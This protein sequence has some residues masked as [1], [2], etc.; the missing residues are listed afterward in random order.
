MLPIGRPSRSVSRQAVPPSTGA[1][2]SIL[3]L[4]YYAARE[5]TV[6]IIAW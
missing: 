6:T 1:I 4:K 5:R 3:D 2:T